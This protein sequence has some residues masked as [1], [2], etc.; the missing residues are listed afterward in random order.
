MYT[1]ETQCDLLKVKKPYQYVGNEY[2]A[3]N[4]DFD[5]A[6][7]R[8]AFAFPDKYEIAISNLGQKLL[9]GIVNSDERFMADRVYAPEID[10]KETSGKIYS[11][12]ILPSII[13]VI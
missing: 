1:V 7:V 9:Y 12:L 13:K 10:Y 3:Y 5:K 11:S 8:M 6:S 4:K 2:L